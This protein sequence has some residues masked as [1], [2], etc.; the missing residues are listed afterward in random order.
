MITPVLEREL[1]AGTQR[2]FRF[3]NGYGASVVQ[4]SFSYG[5]ELAVIRFSGEANDQYTLIYS[6]PITDDV[7]GHNTENDIERLLTKIEALPPYQDC[8]D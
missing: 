6:T 1:N 3:K 8:N 2:I 5:L 4:H 7:I